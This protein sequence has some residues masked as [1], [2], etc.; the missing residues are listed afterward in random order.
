[1]C[2]CVVDNSYHMLLGVVY[3]DG[4]KLVLSLL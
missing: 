1:V 4:A 3:G 2:Y